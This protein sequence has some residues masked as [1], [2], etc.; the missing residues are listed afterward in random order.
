M[1]PGRAVPTE[2][3]TPLVGAG[4]PDPGGAGNGSDV[5]REFFV[6]F[7]VAF[8]LSLTFWVLLALAGKALLGL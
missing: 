3:E 8:A 5:D 6:W 1:A 7:G 4:K 2:V